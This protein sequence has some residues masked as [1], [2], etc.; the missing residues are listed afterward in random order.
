MNN[1]NFK[2]IGV[3]GFGNL[4][5]SSIISVKSLLNTYFYELI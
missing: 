3:K 5:E 1:S 2:K 4:Q